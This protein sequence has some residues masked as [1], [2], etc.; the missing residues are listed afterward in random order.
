MPL[1]VDRQFG[2]RHV[3]A[4]V[5]VAEERLGSVGGPFDGTIDLSGR[6]DADGLFRI[7]EDFGAEAAADVRRDHAQL[8]FWRNA[9]ER[10][11]HHAGHV[12]VL[13]RRIQRQGVGSGIVLSDSRAGLHRVGNQTIVDEVDLGDVCRGGKSRL[14]RRLVAE[15]PVVDHVVGGNVVDLRRAGRGRRRRIGHG[16]QHA[17]V[18]HDL[19][20]GVARLGVG[21]GDHDGDV[22]ADIAHFSCRERR[23][24][25][26]FHRRAVLGMDHPAADEA[27]DL[28]LGDILAGEDCHHSG[29]G[30]RL[31]EVDFVDRRMR[32]RR[33]QEIGVSLAVTVDVV[34]VMALAGNE[35]DVFLALDGG[36]EAGRTHENLPDVAEALLRSRI[37]DLAHGPRPARAISIRRLWL[38]FGRP[39][40]APPASPTSRCCGSRCSGRYCLRARCGSSTRLGSHPCG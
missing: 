15:V 5:R 22:V 30:R 13:T 18:D 40:R 29:H 33:P 3:V 2:V 38:G 8:V 25:A 28:V 24:R 7:D 26:R 27:A 31:G 16:R 11:Q 6:P 1:G 34:D 14:G 19:L 17:V 36:A 32:V 9:N 39:C 20:R 4:A 35:A 23:V 21:V 10:R 12:R 37:V